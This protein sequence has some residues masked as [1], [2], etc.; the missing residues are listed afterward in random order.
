M[1]PINS[2]IWFDVL[3]GKGIKRS[4]KYFEVESLFFLSNLINLFLLCRSLINIHI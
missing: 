2:G 1:A 3:S 4:E